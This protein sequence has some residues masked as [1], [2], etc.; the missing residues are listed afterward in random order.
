MLLHDNTTTIMMWALHGLHNTPAFSL[1]GAKMEGRVVDIYDGDTM[2]VVLN[3]WNVGF[4]KFQVRVGGIDTCEI[5]SK[6]EGQLA[7]A[8]AARTRVF[9]MVTGGNVGAC[10]GTKKEIQK[11]LE[12]A[13]FLVNLEC[14]TFDKYGRLLARVVCTGDKDVAQ[15]L[16][17]GGLANPYN[18][19]TKLGWEEI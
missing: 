15:E 17:E 2:T 9:D 4:F 19:G 7:K 5:R 16:L 18:G 12:D 8:K 13:V 10:P 3:P 1:D 6:D 11:V 14:G